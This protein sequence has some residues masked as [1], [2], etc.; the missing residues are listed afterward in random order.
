[1]NNFFATGGKI[2]PVKVG[3]QIAVVLA[4]VGGLLA[5]VVNNKTVK[6][7]LDG[8]VSSVQTFGG[9]VEQVVKSA[10]I[11]LASRDEVTPALSS[12]VQNGTEVRINRAKSVAVTL[13]GA[14]RE[15]DT[16]ESTVGGLVKQLGVA[17]AARVSLPA[18]T[19]LNVQGSSLNIS[20]PK[21]VNLIVRGKGSK[22]TTTAA[23]VGDVLKEANVTLAKNDVSALPA[24][25]PVTS[26]MTIKVSNVDK[27]QTATTT[28]DIDFDTVKIDD[29]SMDQGTQKVTK[30][31]VKGSVQKTF[32][33]V[34]VDGKEATRTQVSSKVLAQ[35][36]SEEVHVGT[37]VAPAA[38]AGPVTTAGG[39]NVNGGMWDRIAQCE[40]G[41]NWAINTGNGYYGGLQFDIQTWLGNGGG[42]YAPN[43]SLAT[44]AQQIDIANRV[45]AQRGLS[46]WGCGWAA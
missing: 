2:S 28:E 32:R 17:D 38:P 12:G 7:N 19:E 46:P 31:G 5:F 40:S 33:L 20:T 1:M 22:L 34:I 9:N 4:L 14:A 18:D 29:S 15:V 27:D 30:E 37:K 43:A 42:A 16:H 23:T 21:K 8:R 25:T 3:V 10:N 41:G 44:R 24:S 26:D 45:Y 35:P 36:V 39:S 11:D 6:I 13:D